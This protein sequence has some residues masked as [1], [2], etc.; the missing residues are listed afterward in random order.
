MTVPMRHTV[1]DLAMDIYRRINNKHPY[2]NF[3][4]R[5]PLEPIEDGLLKISRQVWA[6]HKKELDEAEKRGFAEGIERAA[7][8]TE[9]YKGTFLGRHWEHERKVISGVVMHIRALGLGEK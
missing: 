6:D 1:K 2:E 8:F 5:D 9:G 4:P 7:K 3:F